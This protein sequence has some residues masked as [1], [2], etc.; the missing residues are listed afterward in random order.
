M[1]DWRTVR[2][3][4]SPDLVDTATSTTTVTTPELH[5]EPWRKWT[6]RAHQYVYDERTYSKRNIA[7][8]TSQATQTIVQAISDVELSV[9]ML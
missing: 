9:A 7:A 5:T 2:G 4:C 8:L 3:D 6:Y 1:T